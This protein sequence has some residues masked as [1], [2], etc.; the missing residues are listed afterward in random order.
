MTDV[1]DNVLAV[2]SVVG[3]KVEARA[4]TVRAMIVEAGQT[5]N[6]EAAGTWKDWHIHCG[7]TGYTSNLRRFLGIMPQIHAANWFQL[8][9]Q[10]GTERILIGAGSEHTFKYS[11]EF[12]VFANDMPRFRW[13]NSGEVH[14]T[15]TR[16]AAPTPPTPLP[17]DVPAAKGLW[18]W[19]SGVVDDLQKTQ[20]FLFIFGLLMAFGFILTATAPGKDVMVSVAQDTSIQYPLYIATMFLGFQAWFWARAIVEFRFV[21]RDNWKSSAVL[22]WIPRLL[23]LIPFVFLELGLFEADRVLPAREDA[24]AAPHII[25][26]IGLLVLLVFMW[27]RSTL[28]AIMHRWHKQVSTP[29]GRAVGAVFLSLKTIVLV[30]GALATI[31]VMAVVLVNPVHFPQSLGTGAVGLF[32]VA[33]IIPPM[34]LLI[35][36]GSIRHIP[37]TPLIFGW[38]LLLSTCVDNHAVRMTPNLGPDPSKRPTLIKAYTDWRAQ[39]LPGPDGTVPIFFVASEGGASRAGYWASEALTELDR[40]S[41]GAFGKHLFAIISVSGGSVGAVGYVA[42]LYDNPLLQGGRLRDSVSEFAGKDFLSPALAG[43]LFPDMLQHVIY[44][45]IL[46]DRATYLEKAWEVS[47]Q[48]HCAKDAA[49]CHDAKLLEQPFLSLWSHPDAGWLPM[50][51]ISGAREEDGRRIITSSFQFDPANEIDADDFYTVMRG[52][53]VRISTAISNGARFPIVSPGG[54][55]KGAV[56]SM[57][58]HILDGGYFDG[59]GVEALREMARTVIRYERDHPDLAGHGRLR[60]IFIILDNGAADKPDKRPPIA[61]DKFATDLLGP[62]NGLNWSKTAHEE[63]LE[64]LLAHDSMG[65]KC[66]DLDCLVPAGL[67]MPKVVFLKACRP[68]PL[69]WVLSGRA[70][71]NLRDSLDGSDCGNPAKMADMVK[72]LVR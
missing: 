31:A 55:L 11:G 6:F 7:P 51:A 29:A 45:A 28:V 40:Q 49:R 20:G 48:D 59:A 42:T 16:L 46:P 36:L 61:P 35:Q 50:L 8:V 69:N 15:A 12:H 58:G 17:A 70:K 10:V 4:R 23:G 34:V 43:L 19:W 22:T 2:G 47:W 27:V 9:G 68:A 62:L 14:L 25:L 38:A 13:S 60:P 41:K 57:G 63:H 66:A 32:A 64:T 53:D 3:V 39:A 1:P 5:W 21:G 26:G 67:L 65:A 18:A 52:R 33:L 44:P 71:Q 54:T 37:V 30:T 24:A 72:S 56:P